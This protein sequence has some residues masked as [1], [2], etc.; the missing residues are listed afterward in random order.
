MVKLVTAESISDAWCEAIRATRQE[1]GNKIFH[2]A[3]SISSPLLEDQDVR[4]RMEKILADQ[5]LQPVDTVANTIM[6]AKWAQ[7]CKDHDD[8]VARYRANYDRVR[9]FSPSN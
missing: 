9:R 3:V 8:V 6:P 5:N 4:D 7:V 1:K 2:L